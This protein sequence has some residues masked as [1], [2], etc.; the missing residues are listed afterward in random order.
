[1]ASAPPGH[2]VCEVGSL[3]TP[4]MVQILIVGVRWD[5]HDFLL[6]YLDDILYYKHISTLLFLIVLSILTSLDHLS[7]NVVWTANIS[8][9]DSAETQCD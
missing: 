5:M 2:H 8:V 6:V 3:H 7:S 9:I 1:M 4:A